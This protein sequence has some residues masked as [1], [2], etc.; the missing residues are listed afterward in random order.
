VKPIHVATFIE[1]LSQEL[2]KPTVK[3]HLAALR[4]LFDWL[5]FGVLTQLWCTRD[6]CGRGVR[7]KPSVPSWLIWSVARS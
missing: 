3:Q 7:A 5:V 6:T 4:A 2:S 1:E